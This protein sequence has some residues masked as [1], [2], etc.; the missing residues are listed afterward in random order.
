MEKESYGSMEK[1]L[2]YVNK[3][4]QLY[5]STGYR[6]A[7]IL[8]RNSEDY[9]V[10]F[11]AFLMD[12]NFCLLPIYIWFLFF[13][14]ILCGILPPAFF[15]LS[16]YIMYALLFVSSIIAMPIFTSRFKGQS[17]GGYYFGLKLVKKDKQE[18][19]ALQL[20]F[21]QVVL[22]GL[23]LMVLGVLFQTFGIL[24]WWVLNGLV[25]LLTPCQQT[26]VD[27]LF[28]TMLVEEPNVEIR[29]EQTKR[30]I[31]PIDL[32]VRSNYSDD[33]TNE[34]EDIFKKAKRLGIHTLSITDHNCARANAPA[35]RFAPLYGI[36][37]IPG[38][39]FD[40]Q[41]Q[42]VRIRILGYYI[43]WTQEIFDDLERESL[44]REKNLS[45]RRVKLF[46]KYS[47][48]AIDTESIM[49][50]SRFQTITSKEITDMVF[51]NDKVSA[52]PFAHRYL[53]KYS[54]LE[55]AKRRFCKD[56]FGKGGPCHVRA[57]YPDARKI[58]KAIHDAGGIAILASWNLDR[59]SD[60][61]IESVMTLGM[62]GIECF[63]PDIEEKTSA[64]C[65]RIVQKYKAFITCGSDYHGTNRPGRYLGVTNCPPKALSLVKILTKAAN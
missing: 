50:K 57:E 22:M 27:L 16:F 44:K 37:Y 56:I 9:L 17:I 13:L 41:F 54:S 14:L 10:H 45:I 24:V 31:T 4:S 48:V 39:E 55:D 23:P 25:V 8:K 52:M 65:I 51:N 12:V 26:L 30:E 15:D 58:L 33:S 5:R 20:I 42:D 62:D 43:D 29:F 61:F 47:G 53:E 28:G 46:E 35:S 32:H 2:A 21:R 36:Q 59:I 18:A 63:G 11:F 3:K 19:N 60:E 49:A 38:V 7:R 64:S 6:Q 1:T 40:A 34:V